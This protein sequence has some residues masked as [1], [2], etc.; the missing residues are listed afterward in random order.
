MLFVL[1]LIPLKAGLLAR[2]KPKGGSLPLKALCC[3]NM[4]LPSLYEA[5]SCGGVLGKHRGYI[6]D[7]DN[8]AA[9]Y[10]MHLT[11]CMYAFTVWLCASDR[12]ASND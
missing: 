7:S 9:C 4:V 5:A 6:L 12:S 1:E 11:C 8:S 2:D 3:M 10:I